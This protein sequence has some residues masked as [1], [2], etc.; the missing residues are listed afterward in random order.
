MS[1]KNGVW[2]VSHIK[3]KMGNIFIVSYYSITMKPKYYVLVTILVIIFVG[4]YFYI[5]QQSSIETQRNYPAASNFDL[6]SIH[7]IKQNNFTSG[8]FNVEGYVVK[9]YTCPPCPPEALCKLCMRDNIVISENNNLLD[10][11][12]L[13][14]KELIIFFNN[15]KQF[16]FGEKYRFSIKILG[17]KST[18]EPI[19]DIELIGYNLI[20]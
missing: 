2:D 3:E 1:G 6:Y 4:I 14:E 13:T 10:T 18:G 7:E 5:Q 9:T 19:N 17:Y 11:Y 15:P 12:A 16:E 20:G 8:N